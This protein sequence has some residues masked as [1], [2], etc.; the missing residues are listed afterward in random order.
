MSPLLVVDTFGVIFRAHYAQISRPLTN[1]EGQNISAWFG[2]L[3]TVLSAIQNWQPRAVLFALESQEPTWRAQLYPEYKKNRQETPP[4]IEAQI[5]LIRETL[6]SLGWPQLQRNGFEADD[7][8]ASLARQCRGEGV[9]LFILSG[10]KDLMQLVD[11]TVRMIVPGKSGLEML[12]AEGVFR[13]KGVW[14]RQILDFLSLIGDDSDNLP[15]VKG[16]GEK[17][18]QA[19]L[20]QYGDLDGIWNNLEALKPGVRKNLEAGREACALTRQLAT[21]RE[22]LDLGLDLGGLGLA[23]KDPDRLLE[24]TLR[25]NARTL[26]TT[27]R[28]TLGKWSQG[29]LF[30][31]EGPSRP[32]APAVKAPAVTGTYVQVTDMDQLAELFGRAREVGVLALDTETTGLDPMRSR[33][34]GFSFCFRS[35]EAYWVPV[36]EDNRDQVLSLLEKLFAE[37]S[38]RVVAHN[39]NY[40]WHVF[41]SQGLKPPSVWF[42]TM[43]AAWL[44]DVNKNGFKLEDVALQY[45][46]ISAPDYQSVVPRGKTL[47]DVDPEQVT[48]YAAKDAD[49]TWRLHEFFHQRLRDEGLSELFFSLELPVQNL[50]CEMEGRGILLDASALEELGR[51]FQSQIERLEAQAYELAG[52]PFNLN[53]TQQLQKVLFEERR[54]VP[55][56]K[57]KTGFS[58]DT[59]TLEELAVLDPLPAIIL[60]YRQVFKLK[61]TY[62]DTLPNLVHP[63]TGRIHTSF[64]ITGTATGRLS[65]KD[66]NLQNIPIRDEEGRAIRGAFRAPEGWKLVSADYSQIEL[67][68]LAHFSKDPILIEAFRQGQDIHRRTAALIFG[69][70]EDQVSAAQRRA[71]K[72]V[73]FGIIYGMSAFRLARELGISRTE[74]AT[75]IDQ[76]FERLGGVRA[77]I[78]AVIRR[79]EEIGFVETLMGRRRPIPLIRSKNQTERQG[80]ERTAV[81]STIQGSAADIMKKAMLDVRDLLRS[82]NDGAAILLQV[83]DEL[84]LE[85]PEDRVNGLM[86][87]LK[88]VMEGAVPLLVPLRVSVEAAVR[89]GDL[90]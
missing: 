53:S 3:K 37:P 85:C 52:H 55:G 12:D 33:W 11:D 84:L 9:P 90:H 89:W 87:D 18:A 32:A 8:I 54:L 62:V 43:T 58:T 80:A 25:Q 46:G 14:P 26:A 83:H 51:R 72:A 7:C 75:I 47:L 56:R 5:P 39:W 27:L 69:T 49:L 20:Q 21:L 64:H 29:D 65:S 4:D 48:A 17:T 35:G 31:R 28:E 63:S 22:D 73:N 42:D 6:E 16:I 71:A 41:R 60:Q 19:L 13:E 23:V 24:L 67:V 74:A 34:L 38:L 15:G 86:E 70:A 88:R 1:P 2:M 57:T 66:P 61:S 44:L 40:D 81:N 36:S 76:Y 78:D 82:R 45:L 59:E 10:D 77:W 30:T 79:T 68:V 50:L